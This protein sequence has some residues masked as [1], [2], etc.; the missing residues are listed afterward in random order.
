[1]CKFI[2]KVQ[3]LLCITIISVLLVNFSSMQVCAF[4]GFS[5]SAYTNWDGSTFTIEEIIGGPAY[6]SQGTFGI[7]NYMGKY[8]QEKYGSYD[9]IK[10]FIFGEDYFM[11][12]EVSIKAYGNDINWLRENLPNLEVLKFDTNSR[13]RGYVFDI[14][15]VS[16]STF[17]GTFHYDQWRGGHQKIKKVLDN[18][19]YSVEHITNYAFNACPSLVEVYFPGVETMGVGVFANCTAL[20]SIN[21]RQ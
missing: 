9:Q 20:P 21:L 10:T 2:N 19:K 7:G 15:D 3:A 12:D 1:M 13:C 6:I 17:D 14:N 5:Y 18:T 11:T 16:T 8:F 4:S